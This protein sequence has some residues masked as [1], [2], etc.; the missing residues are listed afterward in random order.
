MDEGNKI[1][2]YI[3]PV[4]IE[5]TE[6][7]L[8]DHIQ[9]IATVCD[10]AEKMGYS[11]SYFSTLAREMYGIPAGQLVREVRFA[12]IKKSIIKYPYETSFSIAKRTG[13]K[14]D[15]ALYKFLSKHWD[16]NFTE[17]SRKLLSEKEKDSKLDKQ[18]DGI[19]NKLW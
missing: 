18:S 1:Y 7:F 11:R 2:E 13:L 9:E 12:A 10:L 5:Y 17:L 4:P 14:D 19:A 3:D 8:K 16:T 15:Q 6:D